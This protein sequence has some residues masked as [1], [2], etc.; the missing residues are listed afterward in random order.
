M[1]VVPKRGEITQ[2]KD[3]GIDCGN[4]GGTQKFNQVDGCREHDEPK[5]SNYERAL[6]YQLLEARHHALALTGWSNRTGRIRI[7]FELP[8]VVS[9][10][11][12]EEADNCSDPCQRPQKE[13]EIEP[14][15]HEREIDGS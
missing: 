5:R 1:G 13:K 3:L 9:R 8:E 4:A 11:D 2:S 10:A 15:C 6:V 14:R 7:G 12:R